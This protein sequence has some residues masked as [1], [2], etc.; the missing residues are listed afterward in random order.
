MKVMNNT[1]IFAGTTEGRKL[2]EA[3]AESR[4]V[5]GKFIVCAATE[6]GG[7]LLPKSGG[8]LS[9]RTGRLDEDEMETLIKSEKIFRIIDATH[10][11]AAAVSGNIKEAADKS[12]AEYVRLLRAESEI[13]DS[14]T[15]V[16]DTESVVEYLRSHEGKALL[17]TGSKE[18]AAYTALE[19]FGERL[20]ARILPT[21]EM[22]S[23]AFELG[24][25]A[26]HLIC[27]QGPFSY[28][29]NLALLRQTGAAY[30]VTKESGKAGGFEEK[31]SAASAAGVKVIIIGRP[32][33]EEGKSLEE[34][35]KLCGIE[36]HKRESAKWFPEFVDI[37]GKNILV[38]GGGKIASRRINILRDFDVKMTIVAPDIMELEED[39]R[40]MPAFIKRKFEEK[41]LEGRD[42]VLAATNDRELNR[43]IGLLCR[44]KGIKVNVADKKE[45]CDFYFP[46]VVR[47]G[48]LT[49]GITA[50]GLDHSLAVR[51]K[52]LIKNVLERELEQTGADYE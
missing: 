48:N 52:K 24:F 47:Q 19:N 22:V 1:L 35:M 51:G 31:L 7:H 33:C 40:T 21:P 17:T 46:A 50:G 36:E 4:K 32:V 44:E 27:M 8:K 41:D 11:Y 20:Y 42:M 49:V 25:D 10:P 38:V 6:H 9:V 13:S 16:P 39:G 5:Q 30:L 14:Y 26:A 37:S 28:E 29:T 43:T 18:L 15:V 34:V 12:G 23:K 2:A 3:I 45:E